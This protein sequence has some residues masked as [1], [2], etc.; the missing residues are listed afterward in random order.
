[1]PDYDVDVL[2]VERHAA[3][4]S[5]FIPFQTMESPPVREGFLGGYQTFEAVR[6]CEDLNVECACGLGH[7]LPQV[8]HD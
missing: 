2:K 8:L 7:Y 4:R 6:C 5:V 1:M 3:A